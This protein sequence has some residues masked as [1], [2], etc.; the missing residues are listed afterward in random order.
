M[1]AYIISET[2]FLVNTIYFGVLLTFVYDWLRIL[3]RVYKHNTIV[4]SL[5]DFIF[6]TVCSVMFFMLLYHKNNGVIRWFAVAGALIG[7]FFYKLFVSRFF[8]KYVS[9]LWIKINHIIFL[10]LR[11]IAKPVRIA[12]NKTMFTAKGGARKV[13]K[14]SRLVKLKLTQ[15]GKKIKIMVRKK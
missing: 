2:D 10:F 1:S 6:W 5:D 4:V 13:R 8:V 15:L 11:R 9:W 12:M 3:R 14:Q 7:M